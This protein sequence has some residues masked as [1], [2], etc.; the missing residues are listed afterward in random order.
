MT[1]P[2]LAKFNPDQ[3]RGKDGK[4]GHGGGA[5]GRLSD[6]VLAKVAAEPV[7]AADDAYS[8]VPKLA[9]TSAADDV[10][11][12]VREYTDGWIGKA[13]NDHL[14]TGESS[15]PDHAT[16]TADEA[17]SR[18]DEAFRATP[19]V[20]KTITTFRGVK[21]AGKLFGKPGE[22][23]GQEFTDDGFS[24]TSTSARVGA[25]FGQAS[26]QPGMA[27]LSITVPKGTKAVNPDDVGLFG[28]MAREIILNRGSRYKVVSD[29]VIESQ[30]PGQG[31]DS[32]AVTTRTRHIQVELQ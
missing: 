15:W 10:K 7:A 26:A 2:T 27:L 32:Q 30:V 6:A 19:P 25:W 12:A 24:S 22:R 23:T 17:V 16:M 5:A 18:M 1:T 29:K 21:D 9:D 13:L 3:P 14:R 31:L 28:D 11:A 20:K 4:W 8:A